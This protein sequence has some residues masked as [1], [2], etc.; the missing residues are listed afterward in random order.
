[1]FHGQRYRIAGARLTQSPCNRYVVSASAWLAIFSL[2]LPAEET[3]WI[4][5]FLW[6]IG[7]Q[8]MSPTA[9][10]GRIAWSHTQ[11]G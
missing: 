3:V 1:M 9:L 11:L 10:R 8:A 7:V 5:P 4:V 2:R 6:L